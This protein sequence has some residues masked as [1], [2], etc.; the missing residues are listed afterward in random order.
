MERKKIH[1]VA[2]DKALIDPV[3]RWG[4]CRIPEFVVLFSTGFYSPDRRHYYE[5]LLWLSESV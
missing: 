3:V 4:A 1:L 2:I 5:S